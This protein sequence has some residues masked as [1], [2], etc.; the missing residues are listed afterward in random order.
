MTLPHRSLMP[1]MDDPL[2][3]GAFPLELRQEWAQHRERVRQVC[4]AE[5]SSSPLWQARAAKDPHYWDNFSVGQHNLPE[6]A[7]DSEI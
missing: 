7:Q 2:A 1:K 3:E 6:Q 4:V 5:Y